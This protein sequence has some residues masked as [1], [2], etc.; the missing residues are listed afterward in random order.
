MDNFINTLIED[1]ETLHTMPGIRLMVIGIEVTAVIMFIILV[2]L[3]MHRRFIHRKRGE[4]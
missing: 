1:L 2:A 4:E 3:M